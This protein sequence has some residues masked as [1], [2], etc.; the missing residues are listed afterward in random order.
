[1]YYREPRRP[2][3]R[4]QEIIEHI[5][6]LA[7]VAIE[8]NRTQE[9]LRWS[10]AQ[11]AEAQRLTKTGSWAYDPLTGK[12]T[13][14][15][16][17]MFRIFGLD[18]QEGPSS[19]KFWRLVHPEDHDRVR[20]RV[21]REAREHVDDYRIVLSDGTV[22]HI[23]DIRHPVFD[24]VG[25]LVEF[26][27]T[28]V[29]VTER[30]RVEEALRKTQM[31]L[32]HANR[33]ATMGQLTASIA[34]EVSQPIAAAVTNAQ[35]GLR[36]LSAQR[37]DLEEVRQALGRIMEN[38]NRAG[39][40]IGRTRALVK[41]APPRK[42][43]VAIN[44]AILEVVALTHGQAVKNR[45][46]VRTQLWEGLPITEG[47]RVQLQ[48]VVLNLV[49]N[50]IEAMSDTNEGPRD[51]LVST[52]KA[53]PDGV[54]VAVRDSGPGLAPETLKRLFD[55]FYTTKANGMGMGLSICRSIIEAHGGRLWATANSPR[56]AV[57]QFTLPAH[58]GLSLTDQVSASRLPLGEAAAG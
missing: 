42:D 27:V 43:V 54:L 5:T 55:A 40:V 32:A 22:K 47:D 23:H 45:V 19:E 20:E 13:Y 17:E 16:D 4:D 1:M 21:E 11:M 49:V 10:E 6:H 3:R 33:V 18:P 50:A 9:A 2:S 57:F 41:K 53:E 38:G 48:Q 36:W 15:S 30:K 56:G 7:G 52:E 58:P 25:N 28:T 39:E 12:T 44:D 35:A 24:A 8:R 51:L 31:E 29:D 14:L 37:P 46:S 26:V 34:H